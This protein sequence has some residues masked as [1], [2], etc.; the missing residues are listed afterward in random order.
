VYTA[1]PPEAMENSQPM[2]LLRAMSASMAIMAIEQQ[3]TMSMYVAYI[4]TM[5]SLGCSL[6]P[7]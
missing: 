3:G 5:P 6:G 7:R 4:T 1:L 2:L